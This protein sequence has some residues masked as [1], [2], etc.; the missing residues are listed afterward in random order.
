VLEKADITIPRGGVI[1]GRIV[2]E[3]GEPVADAVVSA[4][5]QTWANGRR[6]FV[7][8]G[9]TTQTNDLGHFRLYG[10]SPGDYY[11]SAT[12]RNNEAMVFEM[13]G[14]QIGGPTGSNPS[15]GYAP[16]YYPGTTSPGDAQ[17][18]S[19]GVGQELQNTEFALIAVR[20]A[21]ISGI[22]MNS[23]GKPAEGSMVNAT[24]VSKSGDLGLMIMGG[25]GARTSKEGR[26]TINNVAPGEYLLNVRGMQ[27]ITSTDGGNRMVFTATMGGPGA[28]GSDSEFATLPITVAGEDL[29]NVTLVTSKGG[30]ATGRLVFEGGAKPA[31]LTNVR[32]T[33]MPADFDNAPLAGSGSTVKEDGTFEVKGLAGTRLIRVGNLPSGWMLKGVRLGGSDITDKGAEFK[34]GETVA[35]LEV[36]VTSRLT[37]VVGGVTASNGGAIK[38]Y[39]VVIFSED[40]DTWTLPMSRWVAGARPDQEGRFKIRNLPPGSYYAIALE[41]VEQG[42]WGDPEL[43]ERLREK[44]RRF[45]LGEGSTESLELKIS[46]T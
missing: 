28:G 31:A 32:I 16:T 7:P 22:V 20:L 38:D 43:L 13:V 19:L 11:V 25:S 3:F 29:G 8:S 33:A 6:R 24:P 1:S 5:R 26:F 36:V 17:K 40:P 2:D 41:Y 34:A 15:S 21:K 45:T 14:A 12:L 23:E 42:A 46:E 4:M 10:L 18:I 30:T 27:V 9:R 35:G 44:A 39:T 37:E